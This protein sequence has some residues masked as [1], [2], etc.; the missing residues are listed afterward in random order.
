MMIAKILPQSFYERDTRRVA[1]DLLGKTLVRVEQGTRIAGRIIETEAYGGE[2]D[3]G[4]HCKAGKTPRTAVM[5]GPAGHLYV[6]FVYGMHWLL[7]IVTEKVDT[8]GAVLIRGL[9]ALD[10]KAVIASRRGNQPPARWLDGP[11]K[12]CQAFGI[13]GDYNQK[14]IFQDGAEIFVEDNPRNPDRAVIETPRIGLESVPE[15]WRSIPWRYY[16]D[17]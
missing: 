9:E 2:E 4:C 10:G 12:I 8:P 1:R 7:N 14:Q 17:S 11:A 15:P 16:L 13:T 6:Y 5:Y 3:L